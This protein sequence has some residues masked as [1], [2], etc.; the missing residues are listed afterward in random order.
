MCNLLSSIEPIRKRPVSD[1]ARMLPKIVNL[2]STVEL[3][4]Q[5][6]GYR[7]PLHAIARALAC[8]QYA[9]VLFAANILKLT[10]SIGDCTPLVFASGKIVVVSGQTPHH[11]LYMSQLTRFILEQIQCAMRAEDGTINPCGSLVGRTIFRDCTIHNVVGHAELGCRIN[12]QAMC[13]A[14]PSACKWVPGKMRIVFYN[15]LLSDSSSRSLPGPQVPH[16]AHQQR[17]LPMPE[18]QM[19]LRCQG[20]RV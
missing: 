16:V 18:A 17:T 10:D 7:L 1:E 6:K 3:L 20:S 19:H 12:L 14:A 15:F 9:P 2:V 5:G 13:E 8:A 11:T 4:P